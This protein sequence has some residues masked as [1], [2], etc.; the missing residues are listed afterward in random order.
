[1]RGHVLGMLRSRG[2]PSIFVSGRQGSPRQRRVIVT[3]DEIVQ[4][5]GMVRFVKAITD[6]AP[7]LRG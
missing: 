2:N 7:L 1:M 6:L 3:V 4:R 5:T